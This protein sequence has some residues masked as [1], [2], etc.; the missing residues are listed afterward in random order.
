MIDFIIG[1]IQKKPGLKS[2]RILL[3]IPFIA[4]GGYLLKNPI[5]G[6]SKLIAGFN[7]EFIEREDGFVGLSKLYD[8][9][10]DIKEMEISLMYSALYN[11]DVD[12]I[13]GFSTDG[14]IKEFNLKSLNDDKSYFPP[15]YAAPVVNGKTL[16]KYPQIEIVLNELAG[17]I[18]N[19]M[20]AG[21]NYEVD[22]DKK[23]LGEVAHTFLR[24]IGIESDPKAGSSN[25]YDIVI[26]SKAF[27]ENF[28][29][30]HLFAQV[31][32][33]KSNLKT[34]LELGFGGTKLIF[35]ALKLQE[36]DLYP[37]YTGTGYL[38]LLQKNATEVSDFTNPE[39]IYQDVKYEF[40]SRYDLHW[41]KP[42]GFNNTF[43]LM[44]RTE[45]AD[46]LNIHS[47]SDLSKYLKS[48]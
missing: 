37:E 21:L 41:M 36:I 19:E 11:K 35:D 8:L 44:M 15:Y 31:I 3:I 22:G 42:L 9:P 10:L 20:M 1:G 4:F 2:L 29:L 26:G 17:I 45:H 32:E 43:A 5:G 28:L 24:S 47:I 38:V 33:S 48:K 25:D 23:D 40:R 30:A 7:S 18:S 16:Q 27:T 14:R 46:S 13:D 6:A 34:K 39:I 12:V